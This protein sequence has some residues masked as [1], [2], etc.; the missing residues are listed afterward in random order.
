MY[1]NVCS[2]IHEPKPTYESKIVELV[3]SSR[4]AVE[5]L[6]TEQFVLFYLTF[7]RNNG[8]ESLI[9]VNVTKDRTGITE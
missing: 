4:P 8:R 7:W 3:Q 9:T 5:W 2:V 6:T 1:W